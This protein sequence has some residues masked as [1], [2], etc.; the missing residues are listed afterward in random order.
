M[1]DE[2]LRDV[3]ETATMI[4]QKHGNIAPVFRWG[5]TIADL[6]RRNLESLYGHWKE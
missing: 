5:P 2:L 3:S 6:D 4:Y 1:A